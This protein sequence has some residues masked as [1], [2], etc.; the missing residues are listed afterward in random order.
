MTP[1]LTLDEFTT[2]LRETF[3]PA[4]VSGARTRNERWV[5][6]HAATL[7]VY[8]HEFEV[9]YNFNPMDAD[10]RW[11]T[12]GVDGGPVATAAELRPLIAGVA[13]AR[14]KDASDK[15]NALTG[16]AF[17]LRVIARLF[18]CEP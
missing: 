14:A 11:N 12:A 8:E 18:G 7:K 1:A 5:Q 2:A 16:S 10:K 4:E 6:G 3:A 17:R 13:R 15:A 9:S